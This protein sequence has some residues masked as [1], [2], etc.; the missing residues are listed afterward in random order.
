MWYCILITAN[1]KLVKPV[2]WLVLVFGADV[3]HCQHP[4]RLPRSAMLRHD[5][6]ASGL[7]PGPKS[8]AGPLLS[9]PTEA[10]I[11][12]AAEFSGW[13]RPKVQMESLPWKNTPP[14][15]TDWTTTQTRTSSVHP[16]MICFVWTS[17]GRRSRGT[18]EVIQLLHMQSTSQS[19]CKNPIWALF[20]LIAWSITWWLTAC[21]GEQ[22]FKGATCEVE[23]PRPLWRKHFSSVFCSWTNVVAKETEIHEEDDWHCCNKHRHHRTTPASLCKFRHPKESKKCIRILSFGHHVHPEFW[24]SKFWIPVGLLKHLPFVL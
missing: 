13:T 18:E 11:P 15:A 14:P 10:C 6:L 20:T 8:L 3:T 23:L 12:S 4:P 19:H 1:K 24:M 9:G 5:H 22:P 2:I 21:V 16:Q 7:V 17:S